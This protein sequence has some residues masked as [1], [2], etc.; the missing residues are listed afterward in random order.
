M[1][2]TTYIERL[3]SQLFDNE[4]T[5]SAD[6]FQYSSDN[7][8]HDK[9]YFESVL[10][11]ARSQADN[12]TSVFSVVILEL[13]HDIDDI[14]LENTALFIKENLRLTDELGWIS[15]NAIAA[16]LVDMTSPSAQR[17]V[18]ALCSPEQPLVNENSIE[19]LSYPENTNEIFDG[20][21]IRRRSE[22]LP[23]DLDVNILSQLSG[24]TI[25]TKDISTDGAYLL[26]ESP[27]NPGSEIDIEIS[28]PMNELDYF[29]G[30]G[31]V[32]RTS[33][34]VVHSDEQGTAVEFSK[35]S[36]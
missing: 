33:G 27:I 32:L 28:L 17:F 9:A 19:V 12:E 4:G 36:D 18:S 21:S 29:S 5:E 10:V 7:L 30:E 1:S 25:K 24:D 8:L 14:S 31:V 6:C 11:S 26:T 20:G 35:K 22:R 13:P 23:L 2:R 3:Y 16:Y 34:R 15:D